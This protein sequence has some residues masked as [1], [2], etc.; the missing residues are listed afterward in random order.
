MKRLKLLHIILLTVILFACSSESGEKSELSYK[1]IT[2][3]YPLEYIVQELGEDFLEVETVTPPGA[4]AHTYEPSTK[5][6]IEL[7]EADFF[8]YIGE[9]ME[10]FSETLANT[11]KTEG[12]K[13]LELS[14]YDDLF[15]S[16]NEEDEDHDHSEFDPHFWLDPTRMIIAGEIILEQLNELY[17]EHKENFEDNFIQ[18]KENMI[19]LD[20]Y[21]QTSISQ[22]NNTQILVAHQA[23]NYWESKYGIQQ[24]SIRGLSS[25]QEPSQKQLQNIFQLIEK[26]NIDYIF[27]EKN[28]DDRLV[29]TIAEDLKLQV[30]Y[31]HTLEARTE[32]EVKEGLTYIDLMLE[33]LRVITESR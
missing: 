31:L 20:D 30:V 33:N 14:H 3:L 12:V 28:R 21:F 25:S 19:E 9:G 22:L 6:M 26:N 7:A 23:F 2:S 17:P 16:S 1:V 15:I 5:K 11:L 27:L 29:S 24:L 4:D 32:D 10:A 13:S 8:I 18:F